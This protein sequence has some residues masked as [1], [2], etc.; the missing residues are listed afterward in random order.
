[1]AVLSLSEKIEVMMSCSIFLHASLAEFAKYNNAR[2]D[3]ESC[4]NGLPHAPKIL[5]NALITRADPSTGLVE[6]INYR[7]L[8]ACLT[9]NAAPGRKNSGSPTKQAVRNYLSTIQTQCG[10]HFQLSSE[11]QSLKITFPT[12]PEIYKS[13]FELPEV[14]MTLDILPNT[15]K[16]HV[17]IESQ[18]LFDDAVNKQD[19]I[20]LHTEVNTP[21]SVEMSNAHERDRAKIKQNPTKPNNNKKPISDEFSDLKKPIADDFYPSP[22]VIE[23]A[24]ALGFSKVTDTAEINKFILFNQATGSQWKNYDYLYLTWLKRDAEREQTVKERKE[25]PQPKHLFNTTISGSFNH[26]TYSNVDKS[27]ASQRVIAAWGD[28]LEFCQHTGRFS[29]RATSSPA[30][31]RYLDCDTLGPID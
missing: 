13:Y 11:G 23:K 28:K 27:R 6:N 14:H 19:P 15:D 8:A 9:V 17:S 24:H 1:M 16:T 10:N 7:N 4:F 21:D 25:Q 26:G 22:F 2:T 29:P 31:V 5:V 3:L 30:P 18:G 12:L 20:E